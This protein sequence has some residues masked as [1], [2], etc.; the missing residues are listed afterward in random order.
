MV[1]WQVMWLNKSHI[2]KKTYKNYKL[3]YSRIYKYILYK[4]WN[5]VAQDTKNKNL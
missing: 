2:H 1:T 4:I 5:S 3:L